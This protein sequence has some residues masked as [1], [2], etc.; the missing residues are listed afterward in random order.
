ML[1]THVAAGLA[2]VQVK[3][4]L[5]QFFQLERGHKA[6]GYVLGATLT[7]YSK[8]VRMRVNQ[9]SVGTVRRTLKPAAVGLVR[10]RRFWW[11]SFCLPIFD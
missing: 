6:R 10:V 5:F 2:R 1:G 11:R 8:A 4:R 9:Y 3:D 7:D